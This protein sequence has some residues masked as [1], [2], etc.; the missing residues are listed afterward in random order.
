MLKLKTALALNNL[1]VKFS[2]NIT[3]NIFDV[4]K[5]QKSK[6]LLRH[7]GCVAAFIL[8]NKVAFKISVSVLQSHFLICYGF[9]FF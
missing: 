7:R 1:L 6:F 8:R 9:S 3:P 5:N 4:G 2:T